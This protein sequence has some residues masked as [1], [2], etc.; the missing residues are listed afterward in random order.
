MI[1]FEETLG[2]N[3]IGDWGV[4][5]PAVW[6]FLALCLPTM[7]VTLFCWWLTSRRAEKQAMTR[8]TAETPE[9]AR[10]MA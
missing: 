10:R 2:T 6:L 9:E 8:T 1:I 3:R 4:R 5:W 7:A